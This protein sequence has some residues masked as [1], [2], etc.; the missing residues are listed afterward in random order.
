MRT[1]VYVLTPSARCIG[2]RIA[3]ALDARLASSRSVGLQ[4]RSL[5]QSFRAGEAIIGVCASGILIRIL[6]PLLSDKTG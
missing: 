5:K 4:R 6:A 2:E 1:A 3:A